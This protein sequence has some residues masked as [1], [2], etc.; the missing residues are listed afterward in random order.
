MNTGPA[1]GASSA[2]PLVGTTIVQA[3]PTPADKPAPTGAPPAPNRFAELLR[4]NRAEAPKPAS[5]EPAQTARADTPA[6]SADPG[7]TASIEAKAAPANAAKARAA[8]PKAT[9]EKSAGNGSPQ[10]SEKSDAASGDD[11][12][13]TA[14]PGDRSERPAATASPADRHDPHPL[15]ASDIDGLRR[16]AAA[17]RAEIDDASGSC[18]EGRDASAAS[19]TATRYGPGHA[20]GTASVDAASDRPAVPSEASRDSALGSAADA[21]FQLASGATLPALDSPAAAPAHDRGVDALAASLGVGAA[22]QGADPAAATNLAPTLVLANPVDAPD[23]AAA[24]GVRVSM[25]VQDGVQQ[26][27]LHL[28]PAET[29]PVSIHI[30]LDGTAARVD[31]G[32]DVAA[33][34]AAIERGLPELASALRDAGFTLAGG[35]VSQHAGGRASGDD[36]ARRATA[37]LDSGGNPASTATA[38]DSRRVVRTVAAG[39]VDLYA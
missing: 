22:P 21:R 35:G 32:A 14:D 26:A 7:D 16:G 23:F 39:G 19:G 4:R 18:A 5:T 37:R 31:F 9:T 33:T 6:G 36:E 15:P 2:A 28:N 10:G 38:A 24:L 29:G 11:S 27:E 34:R 17:N 1:R 12:G 25:L 3:A 13:D 20:R 8:M 30:S